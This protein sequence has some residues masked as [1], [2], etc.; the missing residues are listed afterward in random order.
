MR[1]TRKHAIWIGAGLV[2]LVVAGWLVWMSLAPPRVD[3]AKFAPEGALL[4]V[5]V[6]S[7]PD[8]ARGLTTTE[9]WRRLAPPLGLSSQLDYTGPVAEVLG[10]LE[11]GSS[12]AVT[13]GRAQVAVVVTGVE[14]GAEPGVEGSDEAATLVVRPR[15]AIV[16]KTHTRAA[17]AR[18]LAASRLPMLARR[19]FGEATEVVETEY[20]GATIST[21]RGPD[22]AR[23]MVWAVRDDLVV[24]ANGDEP[25]RSVLDA[26]AERAPSLAGSFYLPRLRAAVAADR[27][28]VFAY[29]SKAGVGRLIGVG[30]GLIAG[31]ITSDA[32]RA[33][34][35]SRIFGGISE[36][37]V[38]G[39]AYSGSFEEGRFVDRYFTMLTPPIADA[40]AAQIRPS[41]AESQ[42]LALVPEGVAEVNLVRFERPGKAVDALMTALSSRIDVGLSMTVTQIAIELRRSY[43]VEPTDAVSD[44]LGDEVVF[45]DFGGGQP[46]AVIFAVRDSVAL[47][48]IVTRYLTKDAARMTSE[49]R[50]EFDVLRSTHED[51]RAAAFV[52]RYLVL[53]TRDQIVRAIDARAGAVSGAAAL[54][55]AVAR[56]G[57]TVFATERHDT[58]AAA[59]LLLSISKTMRTSDGGPE[60]LDRPDVRDALAGLA[61]SVARSVVRDGG[62]YSETRSAVGNL[63]YLASF[64]GD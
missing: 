45:V 17:T 5:E 49:S 11:L 55:D 37:A 21:A 6:D 61:P 57:A 58:S 26:A 7:L 19:A 20:S 31:S 52:G 25:I 46:V 23:Q 9:A 15:F 3:M 27:A 63:S 56:D 10:R 39:L 13:L 18:D 48:P 44:A 28:A 53:G 22:P 47:T 4:F 35:V 43:G 12:D 54:R 16:V 33:G 36:G 34:A 24:I 60:L 8:V 50:G 64:F 32:D 40:V 14:A 30:P 29:V 62:I 59:E 42:A 2:G 38:Q 41:T 1:L 51:G